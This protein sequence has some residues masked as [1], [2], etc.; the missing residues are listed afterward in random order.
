MAETDFSKDY[1]EKNLSVKQIR[2]RAD[3]EIVKQRKTIV[4]HPFGTV[5]RNMDGEYCLTRG[6]RN[7]LGEF[8]L[9]F[10]AYNFKRVINIFGVPKLLESIAGQ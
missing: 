1:D 7:V 10:F 2:I 6:L 9:T 8:S 4:E 5:K 3:K